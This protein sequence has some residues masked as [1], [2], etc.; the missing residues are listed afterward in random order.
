MTRCA[1]AF[2][3][4]QGEIVL[5]LSSCRR[6]KVDGA[7]RAI[8]DNNDHGYADGLILTKLDHALWEIAVIVAL[9]F[10]RIVQSQSSRQ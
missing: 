9:C 5:T 8:G 7:A 10:L 3:V 2:A 1:A 6:Q 4:G